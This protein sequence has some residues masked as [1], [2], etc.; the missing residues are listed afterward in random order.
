MS[1][2]TRRASTKPGLL[3]AVALVLGFT[4]LTLD[5]TAPAL[6]RGLA[7]CAFT[8]SRL[9]TCPDLTLS[10]ASYRFADSGA[11]LELTVTVHNMGDATS[12]ATQVASSAVGWPDGSADVGPLRPE[13]AERQGGQTVTVRVQVPDSQRGST[14]EF[15][16]KVNPEQSVPESDTDN[17]TVVIAVVIPPPPPTTSQ[18]PDLILAHAGYRFGDGNKLLKLNVVVLN[19]GAAVSPATRVMASGSGWASRSVELRALQPNEQLPITIT[20][21]VPSGQRGAST[22]FTLAVDPEHT[23]KESNT[24]NDSLPLAVAVP[25][26]PP[27]N[28]LADLALISASHHFADNGDVLVLRVTV[29]NSGGKRSQSTEV[30]SSAVGW[31][32][33]RARVGAL[34]PQGTKRVTMRTPVPAAQRG[35]RT[36]FTLRVDPEGNVPDLNSNNDTIGELVDVAGIPT[37]PDSAF[38]WTEVG[39]G[40]AALA[41]LATVGLAVAGA[42]RSGSAR[43]VR[44]GTR[45]WEGSRS[46]FP[47]AGQESRPPSPTPDYAEQAEPELSSGNGIDAWGGRG[48]EGDDWTDPEPPAPGEATPARVVNTGFASRDQANRPFD[49]ATP[50]VC[51]NTYYFWLEVGPPLAQSIERTPV[52]LPKVEVE[53]RLQVVIFGA[54]LSPTEGEDA[55]ELLLAAD[56]RVRVARPAAKPPTDD[57]DRRLFFS[58]R[59]PAKPGPAQLRCNIYHDQVL[60]Q[61]RL[62][63]ATVLTEPHAGAGWLE[64]ELDYTLAPS[65][66]AGH[67]TRLP[68][69]RLSILLNKTANGTHLLTFVGERKF[70]HSAE[71]DEFA[72]QAMIEQTRGAMRMAAWGQETPWA[73]G[74]SYR[75]SGVDLE[76]LRGD[77]IRFALRGFRLYAAIANQLTGGYEKRVELNELMRTPGLVQIALKGSARRLLPAALFYDYM[78]FETN[79]PSLDDY[80][81]CEQFVDALD[82][83]SPLDELACFRG[84]CPARG[85]GAV[86]CPSGFWGYRHSLGLPVSVADAPDVPTEI[87][88]VNAPRLT[89][90]VSTDPAFVERTNHEIAIRTLI[91]ASSLD[92][93]DSYQALLPTLKAGL[94]DVIYFYCHGGLDRDSWPYVQVGP[95]SDPVLTADVLVTHDVR[96]IKPRPLVFINGCHT[97][98][99]EPE[100]VVEFVSALVGSAQAAGVIGTEITIFEPLATAFGLEY[101]QRFVTGASVGDAVRGARLAL[102]KSGNPLGLV[103]VPFSLASLRMSAA[104]AGADN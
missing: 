1:C 27:A 23:I 90:A 14:T 41:V 71:I 15:T 38:P 12:K 62:V 98:A 40:A 79:R 3:L 6:G 76:R 9:S 83:D 85:E 99:V 73:P 82:A 44:R 39:I 56:G 16:L 52:A 36:T 54:G 88:Y 33:A 18:L 47:T 84:D 75:Y 89:L 25:R 63:T 102:L 61:S 37:H 34:N 95:L 48:Y 69:H 13:S 103:Y 53:T 72:L 11:T 57:L 77:L 30:V 49:Q 10:D 60:L 2:P 94:A 46:E 64:S 100:K 29:K 21:A 22:L 28:N 81:L 45:P 51:N 32:E 93:I 92:Y 7:P 104:V 80:S 86:V 70:Q 8:E 5:K 66:D 78:G 59:A 20:L 4:V 55:G 26:L 31:D 67:L 68:A 50:L 24:A 35:T 101:L 87:T 74:D 43:R 96:W 91:E 17:N 19:A 42:R 58:V 97:T 65:L